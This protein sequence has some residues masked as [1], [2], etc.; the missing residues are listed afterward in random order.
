MRLSHHSY[1][2]V[3]ER[4]RMMRALP[5]LSASQTGIAWLKQFET[6]PDIAAASTLLD[7]LLLLNDT[8]VADAI[9][10]GIDKVASDQGYGR[11]TVALY[12][13]REFDGKVAYLSEV[14]PDAKGIPRK[15]AQKYLGGPVKPTRGKSRVGSEGQVAYLISQMVEKHPERFKNHPH[16]RGIRAKSSPAGAIAIVTDMIGSGDRLNKMLDKFW[17]VPS[18]KSWVSA[19]LVKFYV[20]AAAGTAQG[21]AKVQAHRL[22]PEVI[23]EHVVPT[24]GSW[25]NRAVAKEWMRIVNEC[26]PDAGRGGVARAGYENGAAL[27]ALAS[28]MPNNTPAILH[29]SVAASDKKWRALYDGPIPADLR[30]VFRILDEFEQVAASADSLGVSL[31]PQLSV[32]DGKLILVLSTPWSVRRRRKSVLIAE[33]TGLPHNEVLAS[34]ENA[35]SQGLLDDQGR[36]TEAGQ[37]FLAAGHRK[38]KRRPTIATEQEPYYPYELRILGGKS[39]K[40]RSWIGPDDLQVVVGGGVS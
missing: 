4:S 16:P 17:N 39:S 13:E 26:G 37:H 21:I 12:A 35:M 10:D 9:R 1:I 20:V 40:C 27:V 23:V 15:R 11:R 2:T 25:H 18:V 28:R 30:P 19:R 36:L 3:A 38:E 5:K 31:A 24:I 14:I 34:V 6:A 32:E 22:Q 8:D 7:A 33:M 29:K